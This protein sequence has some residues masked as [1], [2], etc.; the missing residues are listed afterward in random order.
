MLSRP[1]DIL[2][3]TGVVIGHLRGRINVLTLVSN[4]KE[5]FLPLEHFH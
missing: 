3:D 4:Q 1:K 2:L 5:L